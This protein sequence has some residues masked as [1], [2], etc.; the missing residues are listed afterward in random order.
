MYLSVKART[1]YCNSYVLP[2]LDY[3]CTIWGNTTQGNIL[4]VY[5]LQ[6]YAA[7]LIFDDF[8][9]SSSVLIKRLNW[10][11]FHLRIEYNKLILMF[12]A[13]NG[14]AP[15]YLSNLF[16]FQDAQRYSTRSSATQFLCIPKV[17]TELYKKSLTF[18]G[19]KVWN[20]LPNN[21]KNCQSLNEFK[22]LCFRHLNQQWPTQK[23]PLYQYCFLYI[24]FALQFLV[25]F[26]YCTCSQISCHE[27]LIEN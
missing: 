20:N 26:R 23:I 1:I 22:L 6:K 10:L 17:R 8:V 4:K 27:Y 15:D 19:A 13:L 16:K 24:Q 14:Q 25:Q 11:P 12:K 5:R 9:S 21:M 2:Y 7:R 3:C 18:S